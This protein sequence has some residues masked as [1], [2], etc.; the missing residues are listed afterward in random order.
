MQMQRLQLPPTEVDNIPTHNRQLTFNKIALSL[1]NTF[2]AWST[3]SFYSTKLSAITL[4]TSALKNLNV[5]RILL[6]HKNNTGV[7]FIYLSSKNSSPKSGLQ[8]RGASIYCILQY[9]T[10]CKQCLKQSDVLR[11]VEEFKS[12]AQ[13]DDLDTNHSVALCHIFE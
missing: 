13:A 1:S 7:S 8:S 3:V 5:F 6:V 10:T 11:F 4:L 12:Q 2:T 9:W